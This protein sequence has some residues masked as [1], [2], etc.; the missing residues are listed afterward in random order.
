MTTTNELAQVGYWVSAGEGGGD[1]DANSCYC[2]VNGCCCG[3]GGCYCGGNSLSNS[4]IHSYAQTSK[5]TLIHSLSPT[6]TGPHPGAPRADL[7]VAAVQSVLGVAPMQGPGGPAVAHCK[8]GTTGQKRKKCQKRKTCQNG[9]NGQKC[10]AA[11]GRALGV[12]GRSSSGGRR[13]PPGRWPHLQL[14]QLPFADCQIDHF[15]IVS[16]M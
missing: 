12:A 6:P 2:D 11:D 3:G 15:R 16:R 14:D 8:Q 5:L 13:A 9:Q 4:K 10:A 1:C 7:A